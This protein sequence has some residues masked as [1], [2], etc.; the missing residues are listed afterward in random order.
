[1]LRFF[2]KPMLCL[3]LYYCA[4]QFSRYT[5]LSS[6]SQVIELLVLTFELS[7]QEEEKRISISIQQERDL[8]YLDMIS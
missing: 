3:N 4:M 1:M 8:Y 2:M 7:V 5:Y 6:R